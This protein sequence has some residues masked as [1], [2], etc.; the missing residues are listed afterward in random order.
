[1]KSASQLIFVY[2]SLKRG[3]RLHQ[4]L[5]GQEFLG[6]ARTACQYRI[7]DLGEYPGLT[8]VDGG[9][10][11]AGEVYRV[12]TECLQLLDDVEEVGAGMYARRPVNLTEEF[13]GQS[14]DAWFWQRSVRGYPEC[15]GCWPAA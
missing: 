4:L 15:G 10:S 1:M 12:S 2:G 8:E 11:V 14:V 6:A 13:A 3:Y 7:Y 5:A 9:V